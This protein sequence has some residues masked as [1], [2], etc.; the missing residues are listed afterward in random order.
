MYGFDTCLSDFYGECLAIIKA[1][2]VT[3]GFVDVV[4]VEILNFFQ[5]QPVYVLRTLLPTIQAYDF[6]S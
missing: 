2:L 6:M 5:F 3:A 4:V 1:T